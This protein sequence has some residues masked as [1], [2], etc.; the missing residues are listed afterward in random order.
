MMQPFIPANTV[1]KCQDLNCSNYVRINKPYIKS[2][3]QFRCPSC[4]KL[5]YVKPGQQIQSNCFTSCLNCNAQFKVT[6]IYK[7][8]RPYCQVC[9]NINSVTNLK[10][11]TPIMLKMNDIDWIDAS[12]QSWEGFEYPFQF[13]KNDIGIWKKSA[14]G[15]L[16]LTE[17]LLDTSTYKKVFFYQKGEKGGDP[18]Y[19][20]IQDMD[21]V[22][23]YFKALCDYNDLYCHVEGILSCATTW[24]NFWNLCLDIDARSLITEYKTNEFQ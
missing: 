2:I 1:M 23:I 4:L 17:D 7:G 16:C 8:K 15:D 9:R 21:N 20:I 6:Q 11:T 13:C 22:F 24:D 19:A 3:E 14:H 5:P 12:F 18:W 10:Q